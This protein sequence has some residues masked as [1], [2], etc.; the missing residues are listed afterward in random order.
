MYKVA[1]ESMTLLPRRARHS[2][3]I[4]VAVVVA[5]LPYACTRC[6]ETSGGQHG[7]GGSADCVFGHPA[8]AASHPDHHDRA[9]THPHHGHSAAQP[10]HGGKGH[11]HSPI[12]TCCELTGKYA[13]TLTSVPGL[14]DPWGTMVTVIAAAGMPGLRVAPFAYRVPCALPLAHGPPVY[15]RNAALL[16]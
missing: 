15:L 16:I 2:Q 8:A 6:L 4:A 5:W 11:D 1:Y 9:D 10:E 3:L 14:S 7:A 12:D 13:V